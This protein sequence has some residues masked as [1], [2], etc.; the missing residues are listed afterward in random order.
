VD[1]VEAQTVTG[2][3]QLIARGPVASQEAIKL[4]G[5]DG[6]GFFN[7]NSAHPFENPTPL[8]NLVEILLMLV[9]GG[10]LTNTFGRMVGSERQGWALLATMAVLFGLGIVGLYAGELRG[11]PALAS[12]GIDQAAG[13]LQA[14]GNIEG[15]EARFGITGSALFA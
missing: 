1:T 13:P 10:G 2:G 7:V 5:G 3:T 15:K 12:L 4:L 14:G 8:T 11:N 6:G 9:L